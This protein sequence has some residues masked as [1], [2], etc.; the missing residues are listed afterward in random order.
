MKLNEHN[1][2]DYN[3]GETGHQIK[4]LQAKLNKRKIL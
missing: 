1:M 3:D 4:P 2:K